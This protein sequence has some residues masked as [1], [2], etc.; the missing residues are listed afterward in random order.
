MPH[1]ELH[2]LTKRYG[3]STALDHCGL[4]LRYGEFFS[5]LGPSGCGKTT[6]LRIVA[7]FEVPDEG[8][9]ILDSV[10]ITNI[11]P[12]QRDMALVFQAYS[13]FPTMTA[14]RN[15]E[16][17]LR[18]RRRRTKN[19]TAKVMELLELVGLADLGH[20]YPHQLSGGEQ[21]RVAFA[22]ALAIEP[23][24]LLMDEPLSSLDAHVRVQMREEL[25]E[26][27]KRLGITVMYVTHDQE[28]AL[29]VS[30]RV[31][32]MASGRIEQVGTPAE[33]Y[34]EPASSFVANFIGTNNQLPVKVLDGEHGV[35]QFADTRF[36]VHAARGR[37]NADR[38]QLLVR[39]ELM[40]MDLA[41]D[42][43]EL[44]GLIR[45]RVVA[46][47]FM[48]SVTRLKAQTSQSS[49]LSVDVPTPRAGR[50]SV[51]TDVVVHFSPESPRI[52]DTHL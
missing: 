11:R 43:L 40:H 46:R 49:V 3:A 19:R 48:G 2:G 16:F 13:L 52:F 7:G 51:G 23:R 44:D 35:V 6:A 10:S 9:V 1:L 12:S 14:E 39:P 5:L 25:R 29:S 24:V 32:V 30:D 21:Q 17:G 27:Q 4:S 41:S 26:I 37:A 50:L 42:E 36:V 33:I 8:A 18:I 38:L 47:V 22:R 34:R 31:G 15:I 20:R 45:A 28:E